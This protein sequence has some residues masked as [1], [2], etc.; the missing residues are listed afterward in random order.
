MSSNWIMLLAVGAVTSACIGSAAPPQSGDPMT[1]NAPGRGGT[2]ITQEDLRDQSGS[3][4][5][6]LARQVTTMRVI[7]HSPCPGIELRGQN[8]VPGITEPQ[9]YVN[10]T[11]TTDT[12]ILTSLA[13]PDVERV[14]I[15]P[16]GVAPRAGYATSAHG[17]ILV[18]TEDGRE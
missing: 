5:R 4:L 8:T 11:R 1:A 15:Y 16:M 9:V 6:A 12:C 2:I 13:A 17:L 14:E 7:P 3:L 10:G 18:F